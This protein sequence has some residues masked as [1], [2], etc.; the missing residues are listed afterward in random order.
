MLSENSLVLFD[1][2]GTLLRGAGPHHRE[3]LEAGILAEMKL[4]AT[5][6]GIDTAGTLDCDLIRLM[7]EGAKV[8]MDAA[9]PAIEKIAERCEAA[10]LENCAADLRPRVCPGAVALL[11]SLREAGVTMGVVTGNLRAIGWKKLELAGLRDYFA[12]GAFSQDGSTRA[13][14]ARK[15]AERAL[16]LRGQGALGV[17]LIGDHRNDIVAAKMNGFR[18]IAVATGV[19]SEAELWNEEPDL[20]VKD[21]TELSFDN[22]LQAKNFSMVEISSGDKR[23]RSAPIVPLT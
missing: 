8:S 19:L 1:I 20:V 4:R 10:Y 6:E 23:N 21:M 3:A 12:V 16:A 18:S 2:D 9:H 22:V 14:L 11:T 5:T 7:L 13:V 17:T 15:A